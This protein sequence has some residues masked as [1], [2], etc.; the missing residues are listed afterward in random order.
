MSENESKPR[1]EPAADRLAEIEHSKFFTIEQCEW[2]VAEIKRQRAERNDALRAINGMGWGTLTEQIK[3]L[4][5]EHVAEEQRLEAKLAEATRSRDDHAP[6]YASAIR[7]L[8]A[9]NTKLANRCLEA[10]AER[11]AAKAELAAARSLAGRSKK[12]KRLLNRIAKMRCKCGEVCRCIVEAKDMA[13]EAAALLGEPAAEPLSDARSL[14]GA[15]QRI[16]DALPSDSF[17]TIDSLIGDYT[18]M[19]AGNKHFSK[20]VSIAA[21]LLDAA[22]TAK[23]AKT[24][25]P[26]PPICQS[27][28]EHH[29]PE[30]LCPPHEVRSSGDH[31]K[32]TICNRSEPGTA[33]K[34]PEFDRF[35]AEDMAPGP[36]QKRSLVKR[37]LACL[38]ELHAR[39]D[40]EQRQD[41]KEPK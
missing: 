19:I 3:S 8:K 14:A 31:A 29:P 21:A 9:D 22:P 30:S 12:V 15:F 7:E 40:A 6:E 28:D 35:R 32:C 16:M 1:S 37:I 39:L 33:S 36:W 25:P 24:D 26:V 41:A 4:V 2:M 11:D 34:T 18:V 38:A 23:P 17:V 10:Y 20:N 5:A 27:C 13:A